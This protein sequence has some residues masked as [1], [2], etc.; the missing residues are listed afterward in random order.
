MDRAEKNTISRERLLDEAEALFA[1][2]GFHAVT[3][4]EITQAAHCN[5]AAVN[6]YFGNKENL[7]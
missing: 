3:I 4:R 5:L 1:K 6:Y 2:K 7:S